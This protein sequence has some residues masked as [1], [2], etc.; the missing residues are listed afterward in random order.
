M[1]RLG[2][3]AGGLPYTVFLDREGRVAH[4]KLGA[5]KGPDLEQILEGLTRG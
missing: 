2:N 4:R 1:R 5:L 3:S